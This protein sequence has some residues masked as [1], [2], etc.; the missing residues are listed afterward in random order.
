MEDVAMRSGKVRES[1]SRDRRGPIGESR[2]DKLVRLA[3]IRMTHARAVMR[4]LCT[5]GRNYPVTDAQAER[6]IAEVK[7]LAGEVEDAFT[8]KEKPVRSD[9][10]TF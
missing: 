9:E 2:E 5:L 6:I 8:P 7:R 3:Q 1:G 4:R 10:F